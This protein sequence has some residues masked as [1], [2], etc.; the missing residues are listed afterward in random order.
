M[1]TCCTCKPR[2]QL[3]HKAVYPVG[4]FKRSLKDTSSCVVVTLRASS[5]S[6]NKRKKYSVRE[7]E[8]I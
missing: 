6:S 4:T 7:T 1:S 8:A 5:R 3:P 2:V